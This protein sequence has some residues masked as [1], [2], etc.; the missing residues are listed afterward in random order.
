MDDPIMARLLDAALP[1]V[2][3]RRLSTIG[4]VGELEGVLDD[5]KDDQS[6]EHCLVVVAS[7]SERIQRA[8]EDAGGTVVLLMPGLPR[9]PQLPGVNVIDVQYAFEDVEGIADARVSPTLNADSDWPM[10]QSAGAV[11]LDPQHPPNPLG[12]MVVA[13]VK[14]A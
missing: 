14:D 4:L 1:F 12:C 6:N 7:S 3:G 5:W 9:P 13:Q 2:A 10:S 8:V 11:Y